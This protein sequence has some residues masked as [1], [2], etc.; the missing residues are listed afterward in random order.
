M[1]ATCIDCGREFHR[2]EDEGWKLRC[3]PCWIA[4][5]PAHGTAPTPA[6]DPIREE[7][8]GEL[9]ALLM[10]CH[11]D[12]HANSAL[13]NRV[14]KWLLELRDRLETRERTR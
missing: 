3:L 7:I 2:D 14:T 1:I 9:R 6:P 13:A 8:A 5:R 11:P 4:T 12:K 10:L